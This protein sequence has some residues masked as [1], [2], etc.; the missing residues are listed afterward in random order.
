MGLNKL[1]LSFLWHTFL[2]AGRY[3]MEC[4]RDP[5]GIG[6]GWYT[7]VEKGLHA[8]CVLALLLINIF[9]A[10]FINVAYTRFKVEN[11]IMDALVHLVARVT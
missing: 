8:R 4:R 9:F 7:T 2:Q 5:E 6:S 11:D 10:G 3:C 1:S